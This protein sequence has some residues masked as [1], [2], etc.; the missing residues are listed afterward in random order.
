M[1]VVVQV[2]VDGEE[3]V[4]VVTGPDLEDVLGDHSEGVE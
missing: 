1:V 3:D 2:V 4:V